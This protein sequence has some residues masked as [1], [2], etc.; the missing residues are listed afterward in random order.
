MAHAALGE[1]TLLLLAWLRHVTD[2]INQAARYQSSWTW[3]ARNVVAVLREVG[4]A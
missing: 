2:N 4:E 1:A 3:L